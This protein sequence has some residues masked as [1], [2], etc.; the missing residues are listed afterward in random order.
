[1]VIATKSENGWYLL[2]IP[3]SQGHQWPTNPLQR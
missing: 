1:M 2:L 3:D